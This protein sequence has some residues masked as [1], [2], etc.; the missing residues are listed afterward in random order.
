VTGTVAV[1]GLIQVPSPSLPPSTTEVDASAQFTDAEIDRVAAALKL[2]LAAY[3]RR[4]ALEALSYWCLV[5]VPQGDSYSLGLNNFAAI[6]GACDKAAAL[7]L[8]KSGGRYRY[9]SAL[10]AGCAVAF[11]PFWKPGSLVSVAQHNA[12]A[13]A[14]R[15]EVQASCTGSRTGRLSFRIVARGQTTLNQVLGR[16]VPAT[17]GS[18]GPAGKAQLQVTWA[19][20]KTRSAPGP[21]GKAKPGHYAGQT[22]ASGSIA[23]DVT[24]D[25]TGVT[26]LKLAGPVD[27]TDTTSWN[28]TITSSSTTAITASR[29]FSRSYSGGLKIS[30]T[31]ISNVKV[32]YTL[33]GT[34]TSSGSASGSFQISSMSWDD[35]GKHY[36]C[37]GARTSWTAKLD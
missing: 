18:A 27:C 2:A 36:D 30:S 8:K 11:V 12:A 25:G 33:N 31:T 10:K 5:F 16:N 19:Q 26:N 29:A 23:F 17:V 32:S 28:W 21:A 24:A 7:T 35:S 20:P 4:K 9:L 37:T 22:N 13:A 15:S 6:P 14:A 34:L 3:N 1:G